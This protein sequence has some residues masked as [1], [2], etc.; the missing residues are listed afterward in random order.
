MRRRKLLAFVAG[1]TGLF[2][3]CAFESGSE[4]ESTLSTATTTPTDAPT[5]TE[6]PSTATTTPTN[7]PTE[8]PT[9]TPREN[10]D[11]IFVDTRAGSR[12][13]PGTAD[14]PLQTIQEALEF[15]QPGE[16][17]TVRPGRYR[18]T[19]ETVRAGTADAP[20]TVTGPASAVVTGTPEDNIFAIKHSHVHLTGLTFNGLVDQSSKDSPSSYAAGAIHINPE[21]DNDTIEDVSDVMLQDIVIKPAAIGNFQRDFVK[22][23]FTFNSEIGEFKVIGPAGVDYLKSNESAWN[24]EFVYIGRSI[25]G[26]ADVEGATL[27][28]SHNIHVHHIDNSAGYPHAELVDAKPGTRDIHIEYCTDAGGAGRYKDS[29]VV[30][31]KGQNITVRWCDFENWTRDGISVGSWH[32]THPEESEYDIPD[33]ARDEGTDNSI[34]GNRLHNDSG[35]AV[36]YNQDDSGIIEQ[37]GPA[38]QKVVCGNSY[39][40]DTHGDPGKTCGSDIPRGDGIG[41]TGG[42]SPW[43]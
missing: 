20:I 6:T 14:E 2:A 22:C 32:V 43:N 29:P 1:G 38:A 23:D 40:G 37:Y 7:V 39:T 33:A 41:H 16:T 18:E 26:M 5:E 28:P 36:E 34:Y 30:G 3:G 21:A 25:G 13:A 15:A 12:G 19:F 4:T 31:V 8:T 11:T 42:G 35:L 24:S 17:I 27:D 10:P 9:A